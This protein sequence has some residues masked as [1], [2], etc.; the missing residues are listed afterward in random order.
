MTNYIRGLCERTL[1]GEPGSPIK[2]IA[3]TEGVKRDGQELTAANWDVEN[4]VA[5]PV[6]LWVHDYMGN[7]LPIGRADVSLDGKQLIADVHFDQQDEFARQ[8]ESKYR[9]GFL[10][11]VSVGWDDYVRCPKC[12]QR[13]NVGWGIKVFRIKCSGCGEELPLD[14]AIRHE[15]LDISGV[16]VPGDPDALIER[17]R[18]A[19][20][21][22]GLQLSRLLGNEES[23]AIPPHTTEKAPDNVGWDWIEEWGKA[24]DEATFR[25]MSAWVDKTKDSGNKLAY[26]LPHHFASGQ[27]AWHGVAAAMAELFRA[28]A[29]IPEEDRRGVY[30]HLARH[31]KQFEK[32]PP[33]FRSAAELSALDIEALR[34]LFLEGEGEFIIPTGQRSG[35]VLSTRNQ[36]DLQEAMRLIQAVLDRATKE[37]P[38]PENN[39]ENYDASK[40]IEILWAS[41]QKLGG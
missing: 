26:Q 6:F 4:Y 36:G 38:P 39:T 40:A 31:Y 19:L 34:G 35:A 3:S 37:E 15:L 24:G 5:N 28:G 20:G 18:R 32:T 12:D 17:N 33:E 14:T 11:A 9:R 8:I 25:L 2:F 10:N 7:N 30:Y 23:G 22:L 41:I 29:Q 13:L 27:V 1:S 16:P 21:Q